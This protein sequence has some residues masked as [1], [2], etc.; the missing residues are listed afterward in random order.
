MYLEII[1]ELL[2]LLSHSA[3]TD[4]LIS[5]YE[6]KRGKFMESTTVAKFIKLFPASATMSKISSGKKCVTMKLQ[7]YWGEHTLEDLD[8][9]VHFL[10]GVSANHLHLSTMSPGCIAV[11]WLCPTDALPELEKAILAAATSLHFDGVK[12]VTIGGRHVLNPT[13]GIT[14]VLVCSCVSLLCSC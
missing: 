10:L 6:E 1:I 2:S 12:E 8:K 11:H 7:N 14:I 13:K 4:Q 3:T 9:L 5:S